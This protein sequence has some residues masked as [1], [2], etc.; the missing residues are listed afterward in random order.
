MRATPNREASE[1]WYFTATELDLI[2]N[3]PMPTGEQAVR[4]CTRSILGLEAVRALVVWGRTDDWPAEKV[5]M[6][7][8]N[9]RRAW[10]P[11]RLGYYCCRKCSVARWRVLAAAQTTGWKE[12]VSDGLHE[13]PDQP[14]DAEGGRHRYPFFCTLLTLSEMHMTGLDTVRELVK[15]T[16]RDLSEGKP[17]DCS[18]NGRPS[19]PPSHGAANCRSDSILA[20]VPHLSI[21]E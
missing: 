6:R 15:Q 2:D 5:P 11:P 1:P 7:I 3:T 4:S 21:V 8:R 19:P 10:P 18:R 17:H 14:L 12:V 13:F 20:H 9:K 16:A